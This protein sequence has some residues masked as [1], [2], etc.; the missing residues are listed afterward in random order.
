MTL[1]GI[2]LAGWTA[3]VHAQNLP[4]ERPTLQPGERWVYRVVDRWT[5]QET[6]KFEQIYAESVDGRL[7][8][9]VRSLTKDEAPRTVY[10]SADQTPCRT[11]QRSQETV[12]AGVL[13]FPLKAVGDRWS[14]SKLPWPNGKGY[15]EAECEIKGEEKVTVAAG[16]FDTVRIECKG[17][18]TRVFD[19]SGSSRT[20]ETMWYAP[21][22]KRMVRYEFNTYRSDGRP[23]DR[24]TTELVEM[25]LR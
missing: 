7:V 1:A 21:A 12:C 18:R 25:Q 6:S 15:F 17:Q 8:F 9:R 11:M 16:T 5:N 23:D 3:H 10:L 20:D 19:G 24:N 4:V 22:A 14:Y 2:A 13:K